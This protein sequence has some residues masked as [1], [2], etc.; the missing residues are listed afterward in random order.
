MLTGEDGTVVT[1]MR[2]LSA[3][4]A[5]HSRDARADLIERDPVG[6]GQYGDI[7]EFSLNEKRGLLESLK[8]EG[9]RLGPLWQSAAA[10]GALAAPEMEPVLREVLE[11]E[12]RGDDHQMFTDFILRFLQEGSTL[13][14][15][16]GIMIEIVRDDSRWPR[17][18]TAALHAFI[19]NSTGSQDRADELK[20]L[21][22]DIRAER[23][24]DPD[25]ELLGY[26]LFE[27]YPQNLSP[28]EVW[29][30]F[31]A[32][33]D[34]ESFFG[35]YYGFYMLGLPEKPSD[36]QVAEL[37]DSLNERFSGLR[38]TAKNSTRLE[39]LPVKLLA[40]GLRAHGDQLAIGRLYDWL[41][42][43]F[44]RDRPWPATGD[45][46]DIEQIGSWLEHHPD[47]LKAI[48]MEGMARCPV[49]LLAG[50]PP[51]STE[52]HRH[53]RHGPMPG[54]G[55]VPHAHGRRPASMVRRKLAL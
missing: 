55:R 28:S 9:E 29:D 38:P 39:N 26:L 53:G 20:S 52:G 14:S 24:S 19:H 47:L 44:T 37:L 6:V 5:A 21:L 8:R 42:L 10:F 36:E 13:P 31:Y 22:A 23:V 40:R 50:A 25:N 7:G 30:C 17:V 1:E 49:G 11:G 2:G 45:Q 18:I 3:W 51:G 27:L 32:T 48:V 43:G 35:M 4:L 54:I 16:A 46:K 33:R 34:R 41:D 12:D 15:L